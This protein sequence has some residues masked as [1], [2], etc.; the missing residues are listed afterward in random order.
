MNFRNY[1]LN[2]HIDVILFLYRY[3]TCCFI[4]DEIDVL[5]KVKELNLR[6]APIFSI[7]SLKI[8]IKDKLSY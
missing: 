8:F 4:E 1:D 5:E 7:L 2:G 6:L 3:Y